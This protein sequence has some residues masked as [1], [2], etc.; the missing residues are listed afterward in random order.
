M[1]RTTKYAL[2]CFTLACLA[3]CSSGHDAAFSTDADPA[4]PTVETVTDATGEAA[5]DTTSTQLLEVIMRPQEAA[6]PGLRTTSL[7]RP[8][9]LDLDLPAERRVSGTGELI[10]VAAADFDPGLGHLNVAA[11]DDLAV[12][13]SQC[14]TWEYDSLDEAAYC[15]YSIDLTGYTGTPTLSI[16]WDEESYPVLQ[17]EY[18]VALAN[19]ERDRWD[20]YE[21]PLDQVITLGSLAPY[22]SGGGRLVVVPIII[23]SARLLVLHE[24][25]LGA[26]E[27]RATGLQEGEVTFTSTDPVYYASDLPASC[28]LTPECAPVGDQRSWGACTAFATAW[29]A[30][31]HELGRIYGEAGWDLADPA[32]QVS[33]KY[34]YV[35]SGKDPGHFAS[36]YTGRQLA[37]VAADLATHGCATELHA[38][39]DMVY[40][41][42]WSEDAVADADLLKTESCHAIALVDESAID[43]VKYILARRGQTVYFSTNLDQAFRDYTAGE[44]WSYSGPKIGSHAMCIVGYDDSRDAFRVRNSWGG[45][46]G[47]DGHLW[48][49]YDSL[50]S[51]YAYAK[52]GYLKDEY[53]PEVAARFLGAPLDTPPPV[54]VQASQGVS[55]GSISLSWEALAE[56]TQYLVYRDSRAT[57]VATVTELA[58]EDTA[59]PDALGHTYWV[60]AEHPAGTSPCS[61]PATGYIKSVQSTV[62]GVSPTRCAQG[63]LITFE[64]EIEGW[65]EIEY[66]WDFGGAATPNTSAEDTPTVLTGP[67]GDYTATL[68]ITDAIGSDSYE[69]DL[70]VTS[71]YHPICQFSVEDDTGHSY[72]PFV[73]DAGDSY[74]T[75]GRIVLYEWDWDGD[76]TYDEAGTEPA[77]VHYYTEYPAE[78]TVVLQVTDGNGMTDCGSL[79][80]TVLDEFNPPVVSFT[81]D[82][83]DGGWQPPSQIAFDA[84]GTFDY[85]DD[86]TLYEWDLD[87][88]GSFELSGAEQTT[89]SRQYTEHDTTP[90]TLRV[91]DAA[92]LYTDLTR[93]VRIGLGGAIPG[94]DVHGVYNLECND[95]LQLDLAV[96]GGLPAVMVVDRNGM[97]YYIEAQATPADHTDWE[98][99]QLNG[100]FMVGG[101]ASLAVDGSDR[102]LI[103]YFSYLPS[104]GLYFTMRDSGGGWDY[105]TVWT[106]G[107]DRPGIINDLEI[108][109]G[110]PA[111]ACY[112]ECTTPYTEEGVYYARATT[113]EVDGEEDW[114]ITKACE[115]FML[116][117]MLR[118]CEVG[119]LPAVY[120]PQ[121]LLH[122]SRMYYACADTTTPAGEMSWTAHNVD[123]INGTS[124]TGGL[125]DLGGTPL[126]CCALNGTP[127]SLRLARGTTGQPAATADWNF[128]ASGS[129][130]DWL[131]AADLTLAGGVPWAGWVVDS[132][133]PGLRVTKADDANPTTDEDW[134]TTE[135]STGDYWG[136]RMAE[137]AGAPAL[138]FYCMEDDWIYYATPAP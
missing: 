50:L 69:F 16:V 86:I 13:D 130:D 108:V 126:A 10:T 47:D 82:C 18:W 65:G 32:F 106:Q 49:A 9:A 79:P 8:A 56:P 38:P 14:L 15:T 11:H 25:K 93:D 104:R 77:A 33:P 71:G 58:W 21:G 118:L 19:Y 27:V 84:G 2:A 111:I 107:L 87:G 100:A 98:P 59:V 131:I 117:N 137:V 68:Q 102:P 24:L 70:Y 76:G 41:D 30:Y 90:V 43:T 99:E 23:V 101:G 42:D 31:N 54:N 26:A 109:D 37:L 122:S 20:F 12:F 123:L 114:E 36:P 80:V 75:D 119:G 113:T 125:V 128:M 121:G 64:P 72:D 97:L 94:W 66:A 78:H 74:D 48:M 96:V 115:E 55:P 103:S 138:V 116:C 5:V 91:T 129:M 57:P 4:I 81:M 53:S 124:A 133:P 52:A 127:K 40:D 95:E 61:T 45:D 29:G 85:E 51:E 112:L 35:E 62:T 1:L 44:V 89:A 73:F 105:S 6:D 60:R 34:I 63:Q 7:V 136:L 120:W 134:T 135:L 92:G 3:G 28:D 17:D 83:T 22:T 110:R 39:Y 132:D 46:W 88:D 67:A